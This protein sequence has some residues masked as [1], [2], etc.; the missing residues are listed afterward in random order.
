MSCEP[1]VVLHMLY[2]RGV[3]SEKVTSRPG[4]RQRAQAVARIECGAG[5]L[6]ARFQGDSWAREPSP[7]L[8][9]VAVA[10]RGNLPG[11]SRGGGPSARS[12]YPPGKA[13]A[14][15]RELSPM[16]PGECPYAKAD[17]LRGQ[18][19]PDSRGGVSSAHPRLIPVRK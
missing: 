10:L 6:A 4:P 17:A 19:S 11:K 7:G 15:E 3:Y 12:R 13:A 8:P 2:M 14:Y 16:L 9:G 1:A 5:H 18:I